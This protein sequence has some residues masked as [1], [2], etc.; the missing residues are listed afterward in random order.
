MPIFNLQQTKPSLQHNDSRRFSLIRVAC[1]LRRECGHAVVQQCFVMLGMDDHRR[2]MQPPTH[3][4]TE[5]RYRRLSPQVLLY[6]AR[7]RLCPSL[8]CVYVQMKCCT[9]LAQAIQAGRDR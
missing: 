2:H 1:V 8:V 5:A 7:Y 4:A 6:C 3:R 9:Y